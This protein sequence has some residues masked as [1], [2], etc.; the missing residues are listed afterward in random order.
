M[1]ALGNPVPPQSMTISGRGSKIQV[2]QDKAVGLPY[3]EYTLEVS[4]PGF[5]PATLSVV[6]DQPAQILTVGMKLGRMEDVEPPACL[7]FG[8]IP[9][10][11]KAVR[12]RVVQLFG[13]YVTDVPVDEHR[14]FEVR[15]LDCGD[16]LLIA[17]ERTKFLG[18]M[19]VRSSTMPT[20]IEMHPT[21]PDERR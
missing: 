14:Q 6:V 21:R 11:V 1:D 20:R 10:D 19:V 13:S 18:T 7:I 16:Y 12:I 17:M 9:R 8:S 3:G 15:D 2:V 5:A 4:V